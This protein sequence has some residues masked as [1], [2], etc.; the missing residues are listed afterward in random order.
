MLDADNCGKTAHLH[1]NSGEISFHF[2]LFI[3]WNY[4]TAS[5]FTFTEYLNL[6]FIMYL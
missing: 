2:I 6:H 1:E 5:G 3:G 4:F